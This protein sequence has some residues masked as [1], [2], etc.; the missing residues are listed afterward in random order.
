MPPDLI[1]DVGVGVSVIQRLNQ[2]L[3]DC[4][5]L[6]PAAIR[7][8]G[9][10]KADAVIRVLSNVTLVLVLPVKLPLAPNATAHRRTS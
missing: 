5:L 3:Y 8:R 4:L 6:I 9:L 1:S 2:S 10:A 7:V